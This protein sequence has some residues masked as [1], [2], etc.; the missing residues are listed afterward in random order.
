MTQRSP[1]LIDEQSREAASHLAEVPQVGEQV[2]RRRAPPEVGVVV[3]RRAAEERGDVDER[4]EDLVLPAAALLRA[5]RRFSATTARPERGW[6]HDVE[7]ED[8]A[9]KLVELMRAAV[10]VEPR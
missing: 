7:P 6:R 10:M 8:H 2:L 9:V 1:Q 5:D 3:G 4:A